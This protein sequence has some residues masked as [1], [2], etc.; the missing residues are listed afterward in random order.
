MQT[1]T[2]I[3]YNLVAYNRDSR[4]LL[5]E[6]FINYS[7]AVSKANKIVCDQDYTYV[8]LRRIQVQTTTEII[9]QQEWNI[10]LPTETIKDY[11]KSKGN[12]EK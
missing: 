8:S 12:D 4:Y 5:D 1:E 9:P 6:D 11:L 3:K 7:D 10:Y 2:S